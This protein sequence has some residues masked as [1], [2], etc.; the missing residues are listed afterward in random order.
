MIDLLFVLAIWRISKLLMVDDGPFDIFTRVRT[1]LGVYD[2]DIHYPPVGDP[3][4]LPK[5]SIGRL[6][7]CIYCVSLWV[8]ILFVL[9]LTLG[10]YP[11]DFPLVRIFAYSGGAVLIED[12]ID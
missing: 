2:L 7:F 1:H 11:L 6:F 10:G 3:E 8:A 9:G 5:T 12:W 4:P